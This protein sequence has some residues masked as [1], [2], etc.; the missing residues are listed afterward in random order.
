MLSVYI[1][2]LALM[3]PIL[4]TMWFPLQD[5][6]FVLFVAAC[7]RL[8]HIFGLKSHSLFIP[9]ASVISPLASVV[10]PLASV[11]SPLASVVSHLASVVSPLDT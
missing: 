11:V 6:V 7:V 4:V 9:L 2:A 10:S 1:V 3:L 5:S 8:A